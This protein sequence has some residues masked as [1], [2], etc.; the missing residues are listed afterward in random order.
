MREGASIEELVLEMNL[1]KPTIYDWAAK[2]PDFFNSLEHGVALSEAWW[3]K[4]GRK[5]LENKE[6]N[7]TLWFKNMINRFGWSD[8]TINNST[9]TVKH[10]DKL[11]ELE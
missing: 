4:H 2:F 10:E 3:R 6:F 11:K 1:S 9:V 8:R 7:T 5:Q